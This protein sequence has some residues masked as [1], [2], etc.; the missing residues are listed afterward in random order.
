MRK[1]L[2]GGQFFFSFLV[3]ECEMYDQK[4]TRRVTVALSTIERKSKK[5]G[6]KINE[7]KTIYTRYDQK[8][9]DFRFLHFFCLVGTHACYMSAP[10][11]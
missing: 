2:S 9:I 6:L 5:I 4:V 3:A 10:V 1:T 8:I 11:V 7:A